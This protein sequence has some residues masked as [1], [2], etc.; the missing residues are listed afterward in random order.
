ML[1]PSL[2]LVWPR[3]SPER[4]AERRT[5]TLQVAGFRGEGAGSASKI[6]LA[7]S[8]PP[9]DAVWCRAGGRFLQSRLL[10][11]FYPA[12]AFDASRINKFRPPCAL[13]VDGGAAQHLTE[14]MALRGS[15]SSL[16][17]ASGRPRA[18]WRAVALLLLSFALLTA[19]RSKVA[20][21]AVRS[22]YYSTDPLFL[23]R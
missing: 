9:P 20:K 17:P 16:N 4:Q 13:P 3:Q 5:N 15:A 2:S 23:G 21:H 6:G 14:T 11:E 1:P 12:P 22:L 10:L 18:V 19:M 8:V 7:A